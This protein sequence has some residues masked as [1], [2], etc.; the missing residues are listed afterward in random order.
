MNTI[1]WLLVIVLV[2][3]KVV[4]VTPTPYDDLILTTAKGVFKTFWSLLSGKK[5]EKKEE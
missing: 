4:A 2:A 3:D 5:E 1:L